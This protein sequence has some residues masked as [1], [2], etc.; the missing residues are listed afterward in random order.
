M[1]FSSNVPLAML[2]SNLNCPNEIEMQNNVR[3]ISGN[4]DA[5]FALDKHSLHSEYI[6][7]DAY[8]HPQ[9]DTTRTEV[10]EALFRLKYRND[11][12]K[13]EVLAADVVDNLVPRFSKIGFIVP[14]PPSY[15]RKRQPVVEIARAVGQL[16]GVPMF[17]NLLVKRPAASGTQQVKNLQGREAKVAA[18]KGR[19]AIDPVITNKGRWNVLLLDDLFDSGASMEAAC[20]TLQTYEKVNRIYVAAITWK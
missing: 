6:G 4:W 12:S 14:M 15:P 9:F 16:L 17:D 19:F 7:D 5:G 2:C 13:V 10:G 11:Y 1:V 8:G 3:K 18:L 20:A